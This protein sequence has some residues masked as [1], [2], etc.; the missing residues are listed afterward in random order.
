VTRRILACGGEQLLYPSLTTYALGL[1]RRARPRV[2]FIPTASGDSPSYLLSFYRAFAA[3]DCEPAH[4]ALFDRTV[5]DVDAY[6]RAHDL[7]IVGGGNTAN[8]LAIW[9]VH[10]VDRALRAAYAEGVVLS[11]WSAGCLCWF[12]AG[13]TDSFT[14]QL[15]PIRDGLSLLKGSACPHYNSEGRRRPVYTAAIHDGLPSGIALED[16]VIARYDDEKLV[17]IVSARPDGRAFA[18]DTGGERA[19]EVR[20]LAPSA[21]METL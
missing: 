6:V 12:E 16:A 14:P 17:E 20:A 3:A 7:V 15:G 8:M 4:L 2:L 18:V 10:G 1:V 19:L 5:D 21:R 11:G 9:R 13:I